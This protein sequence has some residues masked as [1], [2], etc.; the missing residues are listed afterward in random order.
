MYNVL[1]FSF[2]VEH[3]GFVIFTVFIVCSF[4]FFLARLQC[5]SDMQGSEKKT[6]C[7]S[8]LIVILVSS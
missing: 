8:Q 7:V 4:T 1:H 3:S 2:D 6:H 5:C